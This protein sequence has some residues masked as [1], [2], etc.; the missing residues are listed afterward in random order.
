[1][2]VRDDFCHRWQ[3]DGM[4][5]ARHKADLF[6]SKETNSFFLNVKK[7]SSVIIIAQN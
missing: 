3:N 4:A 7:Y 2:R 6:D 1:M 5:I